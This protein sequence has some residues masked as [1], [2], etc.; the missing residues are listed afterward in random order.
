MYYLCDIKLQIMKTKEFN[1]KNGEIATIIIG[2]R[3]NYGIYDKKTSTFKYIWDKP[4][5]EW[6]ILPYD[7]EP[8]NFG[9]DSVVVTCEKKNFTFGAHN[10]LKKDGTLVSPIWFDACHPFPYGFTQVHSYK[11]GFNLMRQDG[12]LVFQK[13]VD[14][15]NPF[16]KG[17]AVV[18]FKD[19]SY[20]LLD[21]DGNLLWE[22]NI[23]YGEGKHVTGNSKFVWMTLFSKGYGEIA[24]HDYEHDP[25]GHTFIFNLI[26]AKGNVLL[27]TWTKKSVLNLTDYSD[28]D[29]EPIVTLNGINYSISDDRK[30]IR[31]E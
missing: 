29:S 13:W 10:V 16:R 21:K 1:F 22:N 15:I 23:K 11:D 8:E 26:D 3:Y 6:F 19:D 28:S 2:N 9:K 24:K 4:L 17:V 7:S 25:S 14:E 31:K 18:H 20:N 30:L 27:N 5:A 12:T